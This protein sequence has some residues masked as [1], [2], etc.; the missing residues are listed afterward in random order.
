MAKAEISWNRRTEEGVK[1][2]IY[3]HHVGNRWKFFRRARRY[4]QWMEMTDPQLE[5][6]IE[7]LDGV[8]RRIA[9][10]LL[11]PEESARVRKAIL[12]RFPEAKV[13]E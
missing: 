2:E 6:W 7:L 9:R 12:E 3:A 5:D 10:R 1:L 8:E 4:D 11:R 13:G